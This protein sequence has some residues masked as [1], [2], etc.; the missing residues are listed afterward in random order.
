[1]AAGLFLPSASTDAFASASGRWRTLC[2]CEK[3]RDCHSSHD[4]N[5]P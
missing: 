4:Q 1:M 3:S 5:D 2:D